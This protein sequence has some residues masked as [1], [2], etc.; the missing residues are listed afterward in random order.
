MGRRL[1]R[2]SLLFFLSGGDSA[3]A[4]TRR[5]S[6][7]SQR[8]LSL[9]S[10]S[11]SQSRFAFVIPFLTPRVEQANP[12]TAAH[13][14]DHSITVSPPFFELEPS[15]SHS[16][17]PRTSTVPPRPRLGR[18]PAGIEAAAADHPKPDRQSSALSSTSH[19]R[20]SSTRFKVVV[21]FPIP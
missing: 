14:A 10:R 1:D 9:C 19:F 17:S 11:S 4:A 6:G 7:E 12:S 15:P 2:P 18:Y 21:D 16:T 20:P 8:R 3:G 13:R 5:L